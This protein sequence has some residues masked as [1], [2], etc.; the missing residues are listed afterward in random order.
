MPVGKP[1][2]KRA[3]VVGGYG[4]FGTRVCQ[5]LA[6]RGLEVSVAGRDLLRAQRLARELPVMAGEG[7]RS[8]SI[9]A[10]QP[11][12]KLLAAHH[13]VASCAGPFSLLG[14]RLAEACVEANAPYVDLSDDRAQVAGVFALD[15]KF[16]AKGLAAMPACSSLPAISGSLALLVRQERDDAPARARLTLFIGNRNQ[17]G[18]AAVRSAVGVIGR[19]IAAPQGT[20]VGFRD[21]V[22]VELPPPFGPRKVYT[23]E[24]P[25]YDL[26]PPLLGVGALEVRVGFEMG[27]AGA[28]FSFLSRLGSNWGDG[29]ANLLGAFGRP[30][31]GVGHSG[32]AILAELFWP[33]GQR[34]SAA[35]FSAVDGQRAAALPCAIAAARL[36]E[37]RDSDPVGAV[38]PWEVFGVQPFLDELCAAGYTLAT[39]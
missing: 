32:G 13:V 1:N 35:L 2:A 23:F 36:A 7:H 14:T 19:P 28:G 18:A 12:V 29:A 26:L 9:D 16:R 8:F 5:E 27:M 38:T 15:G 37:R 11:D 39:S 21:G 3:L 17:K 30:L 25:D 20:L 6:A 10:L 4:T 22:T 24:S 33:D 34:R 31:S